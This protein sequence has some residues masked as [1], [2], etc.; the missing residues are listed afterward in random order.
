[1]VAIHRLS[2]DIFWLWLLLSGLT[3]SLVVLPLTMGCILAVVL[4]AI[5]TTCI[6]ERFMGL[7]KA[8]LFWRLPMA[9]YGF[10][11]PVLCVIVINV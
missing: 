5:K 1:M 11:V 7:N 2:P 10:L 4:T 8:G 6:S 3:L 9:L